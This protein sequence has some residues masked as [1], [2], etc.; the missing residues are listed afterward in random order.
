MTVPVVARAI[1]CAVAV[2]GAQFVVARIAAGHGTAINVVVAWVPSAILLA[3]GYLLYGQRTRWLARWL[4]HNVAFLVVAA[5]LL[6]GEPLIVVFPMLLTGAT[7]SLT[8]PD[9]PQWAVQ[10]IAL[11]LLLENG[12]RVARWARERREY[13]ARHRQRLLAAEFMA[14]VPDYTEKREEAR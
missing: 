5:V 1:V 4:P 8:A 14:A 3:A 12:R 6:C 9:W 13:A 2:Q 7:A 10:V 11:A